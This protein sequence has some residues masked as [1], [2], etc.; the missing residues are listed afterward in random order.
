M[1]K[2]SDIDL[3]RL[4]LIDELPEPLNRASSHLQIF[5]NYIPGTRFRLR[6]IR[7]PYTGVW[8]H[9]LQQIT[10]AGA[11]IRKTSEIHLNDAEYDMFRIFERNE[12]RKNRY[13]HEFDRVVFA[14]DIYM[15]A[16]A[17]LTTA[18]VEFVSKVEM[19]NFEP[20]PFAVFE[21]TNDKFFAGSSLVGKRYDTVKDEVERIGSGL[22]RQI[23]LSD[24]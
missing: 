17:G 11:R 10:N 18:R 15:G 12:I 21:I 8:T 2:T 20:P 6:K 5:D 3:Y 1:N 4:F 24:E 13:F 23:D 16:L 14:F 19:D 22:P 7:D 9:L